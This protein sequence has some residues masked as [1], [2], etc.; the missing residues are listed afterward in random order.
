MDLTNH[1]QPPSLR[2]K[3]NTRDQTMLLLGVDSI[4]GVI[5]YRKSPAKGTILPGP[6]TRRGTRAVSI[7]SGSYPAAT[8]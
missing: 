2:D 7:Y 5:T 6:G 8:K 4:M 1:K 3:H